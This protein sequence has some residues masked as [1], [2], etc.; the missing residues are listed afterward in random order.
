MPFRFCKALGVVVALAVGAATPLPATAE[1]REPV[2]LSERWDETRATDRKS[3][4]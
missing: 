3:V 4:V 1:S 2:R